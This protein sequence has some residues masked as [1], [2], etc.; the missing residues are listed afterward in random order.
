L[1][2]DAATKGTWASVTIILADVSV[3]DTIQLKG[4]EVTQADETCS[5]LFISK[6]VAPLT[7][8]CSMLAKALAASVP[9]SADEKGA[10]PLGT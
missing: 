6:G 7:V 2:E 9:A 4:F 8:L 3:L 1:L 5:S 10:N